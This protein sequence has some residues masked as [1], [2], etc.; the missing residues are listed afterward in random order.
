MISRIGANTPAFGRIVM[1]DEKQAVNTD[2]VVSLKAEKNAADQDVTEITVRPHAG[3]KN[4][5]LAF[6][7]KLRASGKIEDVVKK[8]NLEA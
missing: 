3:E 6:Q 2:Q 5:G 8:L 1:I 7:D 4:T